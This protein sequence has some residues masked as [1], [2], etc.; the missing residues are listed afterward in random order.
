M[1]ARTRPLS[2]WVP[3]AT[4]LACVCLGS[5]PASEHHMNRRDE[6]TE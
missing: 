6:V 2:V 4:A 3:I 1:Q 5:W